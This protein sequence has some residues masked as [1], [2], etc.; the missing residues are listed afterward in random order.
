MLH[1]DDASK[2]ELEGAQY[3]RIYDYCVAH[4]VQNLFA[5]ISA[6]GYRLCIM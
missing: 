6:A 3:I 5:W 2:L 1:L 4:L